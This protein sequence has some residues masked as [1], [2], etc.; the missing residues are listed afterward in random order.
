MTDTVLSLYISRSEIPADDLKALIERSYATFRSEEVTPLVHLKDNLYLLELF[1][2]PSY[3]FKDCALQFLGNL[4]EYFL[5]RKNEG[6]EG[7]DRHHLTVV[8]ATSGDTGSAAIHGLRGKKDVSVCIL[9]PKGRVSPIQEAQMTTCLDANVYN[10]AVTGTFD[11]CQVSRCPFLCLPAKAELVLT[12]QTGHRQGSVRRP[13]DERVAEPGRR[14]LD[15][16]CPH[17][18]PDRLLLLLVLLPGEE[19]GP[20]PDRRQSALRRAHRKLCALPL[21]HIPHVWIVFVLIHV[22]D[23]SFFFFFSPLQGD[24]LAG[25]FATRMGLP[26]DK[27]V[28]A[29]N[30]NDILDRFWKTGRYE[31]KPARGPEAEGGIAADGAKAHEDGVRE[32][33]SPAMDILVSSNFERLLWFLAH[34]RPGRRSP[35]GSPT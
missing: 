11:D 17:P 23:F 4:F 6:K 35:P 26:V 12:P 9:H 1:H 22:S 19:I 18:R 34:D 2:G 16:L 32:T 14:E 31:K 28:I 7:K 27:L 5:T 24:I 13:R 3:S 25:Y 29:T 21:S 10:L 15:Q 20:L 30:E 8:G 33:L